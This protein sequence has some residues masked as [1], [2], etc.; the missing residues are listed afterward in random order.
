[1]KVGL[2]YA[3]GTNQAFGVK[4]ILPWHIPEDLAFFKRVT[5]GN[6]VIMGRKTYESLPVAHRPLKGRINVVIT[7]KRF[8]QSSPEQGVYYVNSMAE[9]IAVGQTLRVNE[10]WVIGGSQIIKDAEPWAERAVITRVAFNG[11]FDVKA[12]VLDGKEWLLTG[13]K[14]AKA[15]MLKDCRHFYH[16]EMW[17]PRRLVEGGKTYE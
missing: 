13:T 14:P 11:A 6:L 5:M 4:N 12:P 8:M 15:E 1:M 9:A 10:T 2:I 7:R 16:F 3:Q 17:Q